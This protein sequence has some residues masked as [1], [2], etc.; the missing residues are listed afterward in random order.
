MKKQCSGLWALSQVC[1]QCPRT[2]A[3]PAQ[4]T[5]LQIQIE[6]VSE[7]TSTK[8]ALTRNWK[9]LRMRR[10]M[11]A[12]FMAAMV[13]IGLM[14]SLQKRVS[15]KDCSSGWRKMEILAGGSPA[16]SGPYLRGTRQDS[17]GALNEMI[18]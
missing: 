17:G 5:Q 6:R 10:I 16:A 11:S 15:M 7:R 8:R 4:A 12:R 9:V 2:M 13:D 18:W 3:F 1:T 14:G